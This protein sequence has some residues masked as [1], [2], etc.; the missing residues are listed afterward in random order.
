MPRGRVFPRLWLVLLLGA[1]G[2]ASA[3]AAAPSARVGPPPEGARCHACAHLADRRGARLAD[4]RVSCAPCF[5]EA[6]VDLREVERAMSEAARA[7]A[8]RAAIDLS[9]AGAE[10][11]VSVSLE[12][13]DL[14][15][16]LEWAGEEAHPDL[17]AL[18][19]VEAATAHG[20]RRFTIVVL[21]GLPRP[22]LVGALAHELVHVWQ[23]L[24][25]EAAAEA[26][27]RE[28]AALWVQR[29]VLRAHGGARFVAALQESPD[30]VYGGGLRR[31]SALVEAV[32]A[33]EAL[34]R[35]VRGSFP[36][37]Y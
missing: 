33:T 2:C 28:G 29:E 18:T 10:E 32:G 25:G 15:G 22:Y 5:E 3:P 30:P 26:P 24:E 14:P 27:L 16:L 8:D 37:G 11:R 31:F 19:R 12:L 13:V 1:L 21:R 17:R 34:R 6:V 35:S 7:I 36:P 9:A 23:V 20:G 4:G